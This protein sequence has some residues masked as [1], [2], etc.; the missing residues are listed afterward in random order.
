MLLSDRTQYIDAAVNAAKEINRLFSEQGKLPEQAIRAM[1]LEVF[2]RAAGDT[3][4]VP[5]LPVFF[6]CVFDNFTT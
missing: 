4:G 3:I 1:K 6:D 5:G 2:E